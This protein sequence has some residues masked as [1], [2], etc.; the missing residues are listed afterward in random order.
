M[1]RRMRAPGY[2]H[3]LVLLALPVGA[4]AGQTTGLPLRNAGVRTGVEVG[5]E[6]GLGKIA[7]SPPQDDQTVRA[8]AASAAAGL[9]PFGASVTIARADRNTATLDRTTL[10]GAAG[11]RVFGGPLVPLSITWQAAVAVPLGEFDV[12]QD[13]PAERPWRGSVGIGAA[14]TIP[15]PLVGITPWVAPR[16]DYFARQPV[17]GT[18]VKGA[19]AAGL[20]LGFLNGLVLRASYDSRIGWEPAGDAPAGVSIGVGYRFR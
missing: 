12:P 4:L 17:S 18:R 8:L 16:L 11:L 2:A 1:R 14:L 3:A 6:L 19:I 7:D 9:G 5:L 10:T 15:N 20:E 13:A